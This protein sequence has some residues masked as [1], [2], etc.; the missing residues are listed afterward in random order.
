MHEILLPTCAIRVAK[1]SND[2]IKILKEDG[3]LP[4]EGAEEGAAE[5]E[6]VS[7]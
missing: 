4:R 1:S 6:R 7:E 3:E 2:S 5:R